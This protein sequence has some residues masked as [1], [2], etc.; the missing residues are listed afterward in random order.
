LSNTANSYDIVTLHTSHLWALCSKLR[1]QLIE[2]DGFLNYREVSDGKGLTKT[3][4]CFRRATLVD[5]LVLVKCQSGD[6]KELGM[7]ANL[8]LREKF[9]NLSCA[10]D[11]I[12]KGHVKVHEYE[13]EERL[14]GVK[15]GYRYLNGIPS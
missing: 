5:L 12:H 9:F 4:E 2:L 11:T 6:C 15:L 10:L 1:P 8:S 7:V 14:L 3:I 13:V